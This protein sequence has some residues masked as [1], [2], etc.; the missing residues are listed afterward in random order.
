MKVWIYVTFGEY[1]TLKE[2]R[3]TFHLNQ[4]FG[5]IQR[6]LDYFFVSNRLQDF[7]KKTNVFASFSTDHSPVFF[8]FEKGNGSVCG[9]GL[10]KFNKCLISDSE[11]IKSFKN[12]FVKLYVY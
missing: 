3:Y 12:K 10:W 5:F 9:R 8:S 2:K 4:V 11:Y 1:E 7:V 6:R